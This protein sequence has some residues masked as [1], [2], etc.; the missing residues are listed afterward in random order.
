MNYTRP[1]DDQHQDTPQDWLNGALIFARALSLILN[2]NEGIVVDIQGDMINPVDNNDK[3]VVFNK[4]GNIFID[5]LQSP[6]LEKGDRISLIS[7][8]EKY[9]SIHELIKDHISVDL[10]NCEDIED[11][12]FECRR[13]LISLLTPLI[14]DFCLLEDIEIDFEN[15]GIISFDNYNLR[16]YVGGDWQKPIIFKISLVDDNLQVLESE[17]AETLTRDYSKNEEEFLNLLY[18]AK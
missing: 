17:V 9:D 14:L 1:N 12:Q 7:P 4:D 5:S 18:D 3:V 15:F 2:N 11:I 13:K 16:I 6:N 8:G 10:T